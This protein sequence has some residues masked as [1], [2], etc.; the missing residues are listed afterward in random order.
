MDNLLLVLIL[1]ALALTLL[2]LIWRGMRG[3]TTMG[4][5]RLDAYAALRRQSERTVESGRR[6]HV[7]P[8]R[9][10]L[11]TPQSPASAAGLGVLAEL[12]RESGPLPVVTVGAPTLLPASQGAVLRR[13]EAAGRASEA[14]LGDTHF[15]ASPDFPF[16]YAA[17]A[18]VLVAEPEVGGNVAVGHVGSE[19][20]LLAEAGQRQDGEQIL[21]SDDPTAMAVASVFTPHALW[22][23][24]LFAARAYLE[25]SPLQ[26]ASLR[27][28]DVLRWLLAA[29]IIIA[30]L[31]RLLGIIG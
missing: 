21:G 29:G 11:H 17:G 7:T 8:G 14:R 26:L 3:G 9:A 18:T 30:A 19:M 13:S 1:I 28:Q 22:G 24:Q 20:A 23:E 25:R 31:L 5:R 16:A 15:L 2:L 10:D 27:T 4:L 6:L 12:G